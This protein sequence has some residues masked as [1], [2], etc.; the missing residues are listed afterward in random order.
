MTKLL[1]RFLAIVLALLLAARFV[2]G[3]SIDGFKYAVIAALVLGLVNMLVRPILLILT[4]PITLLT[5]GLFIFVINAFLFWAVSTFIDGFA[6]DGFVPALLGA[7]IVSV[8]S[9]VVNRLAQKER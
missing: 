6:V 4:F 2:P 5:L 3:I 7:L 8:V 1:A 9:M